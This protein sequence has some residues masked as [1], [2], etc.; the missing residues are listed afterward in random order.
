MYVAFLAWIWAMLLFAN[1]LDY[2]Y[3]I[4]GSIGMI[5][6]IIYCAKVDS[7]NPAH[8]SHTGFN[9]EDTTR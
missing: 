4:T 9:G 6:A 3:L 2:N 1:T 8:K 5:A 7:K